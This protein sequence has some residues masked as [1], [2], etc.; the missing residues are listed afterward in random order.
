MPKLLPALL[1]AARLV[2]A[3][4][5]TFTDVQLSFVGTELSAS[6]TPATVSACDS[7]LGVC[8][9]GELTISGLRTNGPVVELGDYRSQGF[10]DGLATFAVTGEDPLTARILDASLTNWTDETFFAL[11]EILTPEWLDR[12][13]AGL[14]GLYMTLPGSLNFSDAGLSYFHATVDLRAE[15]MLEDPGTQTPEPSSFGPLSAVV[16]TTWWRCHRRRRIASMLN[17]PPPAAAK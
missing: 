16:L 11:A 15:P 7:A 2:F 8:P 13:G 5:L 12:F 1:L 6:S 3:E 17:G 9:S 4:T 10:V 14:L